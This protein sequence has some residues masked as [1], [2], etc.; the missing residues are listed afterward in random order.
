MGKT[1][2]DTSTLAVGYYTI[3][4]GTKVYYWDGEEWL[5]PYDEKGNLEERY[6]E[7]MYALKEQPKNI[8]SVTKHKW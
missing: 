4:S 3:N 6:N 1:L 2:L 5:D 8:T 7:P